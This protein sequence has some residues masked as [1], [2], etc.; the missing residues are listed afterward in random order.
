MEPMIRNV[1]QI[2]K[3]YIEFILFYFFQNFEILLK[4]LPMISNFIKNPHF[5][6]NL[7]II[8]IL[9]SLTG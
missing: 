8:G 1:N 4:S 3:I 5:Y 7:Q 9:T 2:K 6:R